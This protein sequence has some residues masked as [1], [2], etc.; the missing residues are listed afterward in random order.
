[1]VKNVI[2]SELETKEKISVAYIMDGHETI[3]CKIAQATGE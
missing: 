2:R 3:D 1:M